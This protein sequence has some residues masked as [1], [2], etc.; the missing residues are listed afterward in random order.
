MKR[1][2]LLVCDSLGIGALPDAEAFGDSPQVHTLRSVLS[3]REGEEALPQLANLGV[4]ALAETQPSYLGPALTAKLPELSQGKDTVV[5][6]W[7]MAGHVSHDPFPV[8]PQGFPPEV[9]DLVTEVFGQAPL[10]N[11]PASGTQIIQ[12]LGPLHLQTGAPILYTSSDSVLQIAAHEAVIA[13]DLLH[14]H[15]QTIRQALLHGPHRVNRIIA[16]PFVG[17]SQ[18]GFT[19]TNRRKDFTIPIPAGHLLDELKAAG[20][21]IHAVGKIKDI[22]PN[23]AFDSTYKGSSN[24]DHMQALMDLLSGESHG[25]IFVNL[26]DFDSLYGHRRDCQG[27]ARS[28]VALDRALGPLLA[29]LKEDD[30]LILTADH[31]NDPL[32]PGSDHT[33]EYVPFV[34]TQ[35]GR[36]WPGYH[37]LGTSFADVGATIAHWFG[38]AWQGRPGQSLL[39]DL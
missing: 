39:K 27:Y 38:L 12:E 3:C 30:A 6:H 15:C 5:G 35:K 10:G 31:G 19:R 23:V 33:R 34:M 8:Y 21:P 4:L 24:E 22:F 29:S 11:R 2:I 25:L 28:L 13:P 16:R 14:Q 32:A 36:Q 7:E 9:T 26:L 18:E 17:S 20:I 37:G 1:L